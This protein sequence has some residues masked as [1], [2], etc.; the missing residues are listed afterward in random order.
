M[1]ADP[2]LPE[3][4]T[5]PEP[6]IIELDPF[7]GLQFEV[8]GISPYCEIA[9]NNQNC[10]INAQRYVTYSLDKEKYANGESAVITASIVDG[11]NTDEVTYQLSACT[12]EYEVTNQP[13]YIT[14][15]D[16]LD[17][18]DLEKELNDYID[19]QIAEAKAEENGGNSGLFSIKINNISDDYYKRY[20]TN[21]EYTA[22]YK[23]YLIVIKKIRQD[24]IIPYHTNDEGYCSLHFL[25]HFNA[26]WESRYSGKTGSSDIYVDFIFYNVIA[27]PDGAISWGTASPMLYDFRYKTSLIGPDQLI[28]DA[29]TSQKENYNITSIEW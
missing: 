20:Y 25:Y 11:A 5:A 6:T 27:Y 2:E 28:S 7:E 19:A 16:G 8:S 13:E 3:E 23:A 15:T 21:V 14:S 22:P 29:I 17:F 10:D 26:S 12:S 18:T 4:T 24:D 9:I 1:S